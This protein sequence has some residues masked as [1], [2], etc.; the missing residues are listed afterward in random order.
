MQ[1]KPV[2]KI[3][4]T[5]SSKEKTPDFMKGQQQKETF[6]H[7]LQERLKQAQQQKTETDKS[8]SL[9][10]RRTNVEPTSTFDRYC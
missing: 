8:K 9:V 2:E 1:I 3:Y 5:R 7:L 6:E 10:L 4:P